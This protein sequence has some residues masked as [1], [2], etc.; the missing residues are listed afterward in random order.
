MSSLRNQLNY[1]CEK[2]KWRELA[3]LYQ[4][5]QKQDFKPDSF[6]FT[7]LLKSTSN[8]HFRPLHQ[9]RAI[10]ADA[11]KRGFVESDNYVA[12]ALVAMY[13]Q[14]NSLHD[15]RKVFDGI[16]EAN[17]ANPVNWNT[18]ISCF[19]RGGDHKGAY[20]LF[21]L[22]KCPNDITW[23]AV[24]AGYVQNGKLVDALR[25][26]KKMRGE[27]DEIGFCVS[28]YSDTIAT[29]FSACGQLRDLC[30]GEQVHGY[31]IKI[32]P[33]VENDGFVGSSLVDLYGKCS[34][35]ELAKLVFDS[36]V[37]K[38][39]VAWSA[40]I[41][42]Y[43]S[44]GCPSR[45]IDIFREMVYEGPEPNYVTLS[46]LITA[47][48][49]IP[50]LTFGKELHGF[51]VRRSEFTHDAYMSTSLIN[52][53]SKCHCMICA[54]N[55]FEIA[56]NTLEFNA[57]PVY[58]ATIAGYVENDCQDEAWEIF[59]SMHQE[60]SATPNS[61][62]MA[63]VIPLCTMSSSLHYGKEVHCY[64]LKSG[65]TENIFVGNSLLDMYSKCG[66]LHVA[67]NQFKM[68]VKKNRI[69]WTSMIDGYGI[70]GDGEGAIRIFQKMVRESD[71][72]PDQVTFVALIS[73]C[74]HAGL[75]EEG[76]TYFKEMDKEYGIT[77]LD[78]NYGSVVDLLARAGRLDEAKSFIAAMPKKPGPSVWGALLG[79]CKIHGEV[80]E[81]EKAA[82]ILLKLE[83][84]EDGFQ[85]LL[86]SLYSETGML[87]KREE[88]ISEMRERGI[89]NRQGL[90][91]LETGKRNYRF[92]S[93]DM[94][95][96]C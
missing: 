54:R 73:A 27:S 18:A 20:E 86:S 59:R 30:F 26:F 6:T 28:P 68:I 53:Y 51:I 15:A 85:K 79:A 5:I 42:S 14:C 7:T 63:I 24:I 32:S 78:E 48:A 94:G 83:P 29:V 40:L 90:S 70:H 37:E 87:D 41:A 60:G 11:S 8:H 65:L 80:E 22:M 57:T 50:N 10:H 56:I 47:C 93:E 64:S 21:C 55:I 72:K 16:R 74:S 3:A 44:N 33:Y 4:E 89:S 39:V 92:I 1:F 52:M 17:L 91:W 82:K 95:L 19:F 34:C 38:C 2:G 76:L 35:L 66:K 67:E 23:S 43:V 69:T 45:G 12:N 81:A 61:V 49:N 46:S 9:G 71:V 36:M 62:T 96:V 84:K 77:P 75:V 13:A 58:N 25:V 88:A 31:A